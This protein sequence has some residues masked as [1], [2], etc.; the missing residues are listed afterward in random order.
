MI[1]F[2]CKDENKK[3]TAE[4]QRKKKNVLVEQWVVVGVSGRDERER[5]RRGGCG[6]GD[7]PIYT[8]AVLK[9]CKPLILGIVE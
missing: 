6:T 7:W 2:F 5:E 1:F 4:G 8:R 9:R 3:R